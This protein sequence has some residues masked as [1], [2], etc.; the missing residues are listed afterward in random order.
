L[1]NT[2]SSELKNYIKVLKT[3][4]ECGFAV[5]ANSADNHAIN[6]KFYTHELCHRTLLSF[7]QHPFLI[8]EKI[9]LRFDLVHI[10]KN[11]Y[12]N[13]VNQKIFD[14]PEFDGET[15]GQ[16]EFSHKEELFHIECGKPIRM[17]FKAE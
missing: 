11:I 14:F 10:F 8:G 6:I 4:T 1:L 12:N 3:L 9:F 2:I 16:A 17:A 13:F 15:I 7:V 5:V